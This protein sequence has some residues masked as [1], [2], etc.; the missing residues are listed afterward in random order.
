MLRSSR[1]TP[2]GARDFMP[3]IVGSSIINQLFNKRSLRPARQ[4]R[5]S[6]LER[7][8]KNTCNKGSIII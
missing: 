2:Q 5:G 6:G 8:E 7:E 4:L 3:F 1:S